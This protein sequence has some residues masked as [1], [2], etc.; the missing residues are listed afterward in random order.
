[1]GVLNSKGIAPL[2]VIYVFLMFN[3]PGPGLLAISN[4]ETHRNDLLRDRLHLS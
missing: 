2:G 3:P 4:N 1:M